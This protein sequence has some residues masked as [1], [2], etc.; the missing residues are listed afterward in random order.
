[1]FEDGNG[2]SGEEF[3]SGIM[4][5]ILKKTDEADDTVIIMPGAVLCIP[6]PTR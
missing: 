5:Y 2:E 3:E 4:Y 6:C 1:M